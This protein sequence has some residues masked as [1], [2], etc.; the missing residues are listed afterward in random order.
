MLCAIGWFSEL[1]L[2]KNSR[3]L[4]VPKFQDFSGI[5][6][7]LLSL[8]NE[9]L[10]S[11]FSAVFVNNVVSRSSTFPCF[12]FC[13]N[14]SVWAT[15]KL[16]GFPVKIEINAFAVTRQ[17]FTTNSQSKSS[18]PSLLLKLTCT[19]FSFYDIFQFFFHILVLVN[20]KLV[21]YFLPNH[22]LF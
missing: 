5:L 16:A 21:W 9:I 13:K 11:F 10:I 4:S 17:S 18:H 22:N 19:R 1:N 3:F 12:A 6:S 8:R 7:Y 15:V 14:N 20:R 2:T